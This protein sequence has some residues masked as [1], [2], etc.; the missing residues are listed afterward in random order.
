MTICSA[1]A[2]L[3]MLAKAEGREKHVCDPSCKYWKFPHLDK[4]CVLSEVFSVRKGELCTE[5]VNEEDE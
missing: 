3:E 1:H 5:Y 4:A 2:I